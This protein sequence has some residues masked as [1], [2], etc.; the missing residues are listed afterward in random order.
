MRLIALRKLFRMGDE[1]QLT[2]LK[3]VDLS[4]KPGEFLAI[5]GRMRFVES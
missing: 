2:I 5:E 3:N 4:I 1:E